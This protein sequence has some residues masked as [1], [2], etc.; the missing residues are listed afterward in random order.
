M[1]TKRYPPN[2]PHEPHVGSVSDG[3]LSSRGEA[4]SDGQQQTTSPCSAADVVKSSLT[5][6][7]RGT[8]TEVVA[9][10]LCL[11][12]NN[13][14]WNRRSLRAS[15]ANNLLRLH[16]THDTGRQK[17]GWQRRPRSHTAGKRVDQTRMTTV[18]INPG[19]VST[20]HE[21]ERLSQALPD[22]STSPCSRAEERRA[23]DNG[24]RILTAQRVGSPHML[25]RESSTDRGRECFLPS[26]CLIPTIQ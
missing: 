3:E 20:L 5:D 7:F 8:R 1:L 9:A 18:H 4:K 23:D 17:K 2:Y 13:Q 21:T 6:H 11:G 12:A 19:N 26:P 10:N 14:T 22:A 16:Q 15:A 25:L 24:Q